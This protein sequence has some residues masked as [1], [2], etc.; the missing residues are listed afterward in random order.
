MKELNVLL[1]L[2]I[3]ELKVQSKPKDEI[4]EKIKELVTFI[5]K[6]LDKGLF[7]LTGD[8]DLARFTKKYGLT[9]QSLLD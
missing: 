4:I 7:I 2:Q 3:Q 5:E 8:N 1:D 6:N 9:N